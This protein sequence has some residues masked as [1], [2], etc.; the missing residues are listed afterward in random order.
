MI[1]YDVNYYSA[2]MKSE[3]FFFMAFHLVR[4]T[5]V[6]YVMVEGFIYLLLL[7]TCTSTVN[8]YYEYIQHNTNYFHENVFN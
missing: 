5:F 3:I 7:L 2:Y 8:N 4:L 6:F 1:K